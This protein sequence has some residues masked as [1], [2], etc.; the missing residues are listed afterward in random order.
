MRRIATLAAVLV[1]IALPASA[2][3]QFPYRPQGAPDDYTKYY[4]PPSAPVPNDLGGKLDWMYASTPAAPGPGQP[5]NPLTL[6]KRE[7]GGVR[8]AVGVDR[9]RTASQ[10]WATTTG[11]PDV[12]IAVLDSGIMWNNWGKPLDDVRLHVR[13]NKGEPPVPIDDRA[14]STD[15]LVPNCGALAARAGERDLNGDGV[16]NIL[17]YACDSRVDPAPVHGVGPTVNGKPVL[18]PE[19][20]I[21]A[22]SNQDDHDGNGYVDDV[23]GWDFLDDD[24]D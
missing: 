4:L 11:R 16:F 20:L 19:D 5:V 18:D 21:I 3:A 2:L 10:A 17:D 23:A 12:T 15:D 6:E 1:T 13:L 14:S 7:R 24:N 9:D 22:F 8:G